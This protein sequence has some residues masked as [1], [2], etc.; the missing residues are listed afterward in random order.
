MFDTARVCSALR[1]PNEPQTPQTQTESD[2]RYGSFDFRA[3]HA[4]APAD[5]QEL[6]DQH[7][8]LPFRRRG[9]E[10]DGMLK[11]VVDRAGMAQMYASAQ[12]GADATVQALAAVPS[13]INHFNNDALFERPV[14][15][16]LVELLVLDTADRRFTSCVV[17]HGMGGTGKTVTA[18][19]AVQERAVRACFSEI[20]WLTVGADAVGEKIQQLAAT[21]FKQLTGAT[22]KGD[23]KDDHERQAML[24]TALAGKQGRVLVVLDDPWMSEQV[25]FLNPI[26]SSQSKK[27][28][29]LITTRIRD[30]VPKATRLE[31]PL[32][33]RDEAVALL[34][35]LAN[36]EE[37][38]YLK[39]HPGS[40][41]PPRAAYTI[42]AECGLLPVTLTIAA[43]VVRSWGDG[44]GEWLSRMR[45]AFD[46]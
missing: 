46:D 25:R 35:E 19:A 23:G 12:E 3:A 41:W 18:V 13:E 17:V 1:S 44:W 32:M 31:L 30:L 28:R 16:E 38:E 24:V 14:Q 2:A 7:E 21:L 42:A 20:H 5:L 10:R 15:V 40:A 45:I 11:T 36:V 6:L 34:L 43:Q 27:H 37:A 29:L 4:E 26:D 22:M 39:D 33:G 8:S 9:Y